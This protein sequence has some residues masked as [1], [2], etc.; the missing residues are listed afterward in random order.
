LAQVPSTIAGR[1][2]RMACADGE[3]AHLEGLAAELEGRIS[4]ATAQL[5]ESVALEQ[6]NAESSAAAAAAAA[7]AAQAQVA[8]AAV[9][10]ASD[11]L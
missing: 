5:G 6:A 10:A 7:A 9:A 11:Q 1:T 2:Y 4:A 8:Q 3:E